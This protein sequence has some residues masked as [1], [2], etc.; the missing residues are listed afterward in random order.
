[1]DR[2][3]PENPP[4]AAVALSKPTGCASHPHK[5]AMSGTVPAPARR[6]RRKRDGR[7]ASLKSAPGSYFD[8]LRIRCRAK[9]ACVELAELSLSYREVRVRSRPLDCSVSK[10][11]VRDVYDASS[12][13]KPV[14]RARFEETLRRARHSKLI[15]SRRGYDKS[16]G[17]WLPNALS[18]QARRAL[19][20]NHC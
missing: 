6:S 2:S 16:L 8:A 11:W 15:P 3:L 17:G 19:S 13:M 10:F 7:K 20:R 1:V 18:Q 9:G 5:A 4:L 14:E 12:E